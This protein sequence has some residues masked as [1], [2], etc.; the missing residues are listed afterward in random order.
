[1]NNPARLLAALSL[2][3]SAPIIAAGV[4]DEA[5]PQV[6]A[7]D[8]DTVRAS[9]KVL[10]ALWTRR[11]DS[12]TL[13]LVMP[14]VSTVRPGNPQAARVSTEKPPTPRPPQVEVWL[15]KADGSRLLPSS[16][17]IPPI[18]RQYACGRCVSYELGY[19][20][21]HAIARDAVAAAVRI[22][23]TV[24]VATLKPLGD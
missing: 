16:Q 11:P 6:L 17:S 4:A 3:L 24:Y 20:F 23:D 1:M 15:L 12:Y 2:A 10:A 5:K 18:A 21:A 9:G 8:L 19:S 22:D 13:Q 14:V 7:Q